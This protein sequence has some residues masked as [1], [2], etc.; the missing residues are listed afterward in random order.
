MHRSLTAKTHVTGA[1]P[2]SLFRLIKI[3]IVSSTFNPKLK[4]PHFILIYLQLNLNIIGLNW[5]PGELNGLASVK[6]G[7]LLK[8]TNQA[9]SSSFS[10]ADTERSRLHSSCQ[11]TQFPYF[12]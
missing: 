6:Y 12:A 9:I 3:R 1:A 8:A 11:E 5:I 10:L 7:A 4:I 2:F